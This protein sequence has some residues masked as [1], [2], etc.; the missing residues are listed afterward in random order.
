MRSI[1]INDDE[2][3]I[4]QGEKI[5][6]QTKHKII[7]RKLSEVKDIHWEGRGEIDTKTIYSLLRRGI[8][9]Y[10]HEPYGKFIGSALPLPYFSYSGKILLKQSEYI[11]NNEKR[12]R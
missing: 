8:I 2:K 1:I 11:N 5:S 4:V 9:I 10:F 12:F 7:E 6:I 3:L